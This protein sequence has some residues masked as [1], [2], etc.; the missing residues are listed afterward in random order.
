MTTPVYVASP[1]WHAPTVVRDCDDHWHHDPERCPRI[2]RGD[3]T[4]PCPTC[5]TDLRWFDVPGGLVDDFDWLPDVCNNTLVS[6]WTG[7]NINDPLIADGMWRMWEAR[8]A[9]ESEESSARAWA[10]AIG[11][12]AEAAAVADRL[13]VLGTRT[14]WASGGKVHAV[15]ACPNCGVAHDVTRR[16]VM[17]VQTI[18]PP[19]PV[20][21]DN[22]WSNLAVRWRWFGRRYV[23]EAMM[24]YLIGDSQYENAAETRAPQLRRWHVARTHSFEARA[25]SDP[26][27]QRT[28]ITV[29]S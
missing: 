10:Q 2:C 5:K 20:T 28:K 16:D 23:P 26:K 22:C 12:A 9:T 21:C 4:R 17:A 19:V 25:S 24:T 11:N 8:R 6:G 27:R 18:V 15:I 7:R 14:A 1:R 13:A 29:W 3:R